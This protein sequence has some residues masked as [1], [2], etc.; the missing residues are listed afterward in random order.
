MRIDV[1]QFAAILKQ[2][3]DILLMMHEQ[4]DGDTTGGA[5]GLWAA[6]TALGKRCAVQCLSSIPESFAFITDGIDFEQFIPKLTVA[7]DVADIKLLGDGY[8]RFKGKIDLCIDHHTSN[9]DYSDKLLLEDKAAAC[10]IVLEVLYEL[11]IKPDKYMATCIYTGIATDTGCFRYTNTTSGTLRSAADM[12]DVGIDTEMINK[13]MFET[14]TKSFMRLEKLAR[15]TLEMHF[16][17]RCALITV[18]QEMFR[19]SGSNESECH[20]IT[21]STRQI[22]GVLVGASIKEQKDGGYNISVRTNGSIDASAICRR[23]GGGGHRNAA[24]CE[25]TGELCE[26]KKILLENIGEA[27]A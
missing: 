11:G 18:T 7:V 9:V 8:E 24:G 20:P 21:A 2:S 4:P 14:K 1:R 5:Y 10:E 17:E 3:D 27:L 15:E 16:D 25:L 22:E 13:L 26:V 19:K 23:M 12:M 6:L